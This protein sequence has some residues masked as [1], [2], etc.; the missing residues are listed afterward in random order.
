MRGG[1]AHGFESS[2]GLS[3]SKDNGN[4]SPRDR[5]CRPRY[6]DAAA[7][8]SRAFAT[9]PPPAPGLLQMDDWSELSNPRDVSKIFT[10]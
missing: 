7:H 8:G 2:N 4:A 9:A 6:R 5:T 3:Q 10:A 1:D